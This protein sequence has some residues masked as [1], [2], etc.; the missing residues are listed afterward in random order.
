MLDLCRQKGENCVRGAWM[1]AF[2]SFVCLYYYL[3]GRGQS[4]RQ[5][6]FIYGY[7]SYLRLD[8]IALTL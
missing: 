7:F 4:L 5:D 2:G 6:Q 8:E 1:D 3:A